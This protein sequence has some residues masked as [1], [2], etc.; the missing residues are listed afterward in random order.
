[1]TQ[2]RQPPANPGRFTPAKSDDSGPIGIGACDLDSILD[3]LG[4]GREKNAF[5]VFAATN[6]SIEPRRQRDVRFIPNYL[7]AGLT[8]PIELPSYGSYDARMIVTDIENANSTREVELA[9]AIRIPNMCA[10]GAIDKDWV[11]GHQPSCDTRA[12][13]RLWVTLSQ[14]NIRFSTQSTP[15][16]THRVTASPGLPMKILRALI[17]RESPSFRQIRREIPGMRA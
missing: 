13:A 7:E 15:S 12:I 4:S 1:V 14:M 11:R 16:P 6:E 2:T 8:C 17:R 3:R 10:F 5:E 9:L